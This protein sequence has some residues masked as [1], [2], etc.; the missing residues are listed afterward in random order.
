[1]E[2][3]SIEKSISVVICTYNGEN[4][5]REQLD[6]IL[7][8]TYPI[9]MIYVQDDCSTDDTVQ[10]LKEYAEKYSNVCYRV[11]TEQLGVNR[12]FFTAFNQVDAE[13]TAISDQD[14]IWELDKVEKQMGMIGDNWLCCCLSKSFSTD[15][16]AVHFDERIP[17]HTPLKLIFYNVIAGHTI[18]F[19]R[20]ILKYVSIDSSIMY[21]WQLAYIASSYNKIYFLPESLVNH[22]RHA[23]AVTYTKPLN[24]RKTLFNGFRLIFYS[25]KLLSE[26]KDVVRNSFTANLEFLETLSGESCDFQ[27]AKRLCQLLCRQ[28]IVASLKASRICLR[29]RDKLFYQKEKNPILAVC[30]ALLQPLLLYTSFDSRRICGLPTF[31]RRNS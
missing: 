25:V 12:N 30:R 8:Q 21:D 6:S 3:N 9:K 22:R 28:T 16:L 5:I 10:I 27:E 15:G 17:N 23:A 24:T 11:N 4:Y 29:N 31:T 19:R 2:R 26:N 7:N 20:E 14:D 1:M 18:L 13:Y